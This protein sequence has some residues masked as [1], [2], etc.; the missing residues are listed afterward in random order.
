MA[1]ITDSTTRGEYAVGDEFPDGKVVAATR[2]TVARDGG[3]L[4]AYAVDRPNIYYP[5]TTIRTWFAAER[6]ERTYGDDVGL[7]KFMHALA[8]HS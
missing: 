2:E 4:I 3:R 7:A 1:K 6:P 5:G 8:D